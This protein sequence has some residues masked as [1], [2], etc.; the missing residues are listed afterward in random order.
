M[1]YTLAENGQAPKFLGKVSKQG[2]PSNAI[3]ITIACLL[4][5]VFLNYIYPN[6]KLF[7]YI[8]SASILPGMIPWFVLCISQIKFRKKWGSEMGTHPFKSSLFPI[9][10][11]I[12]IIFLCLV[13]VGMW[14][15]D[16]TQVSLIVGAV[17][18]AIITVFYYALGI[19]KKQLP[20]QLDEKL[21]TVDP[22]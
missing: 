18:C 7:V 13:L 6:S 9:S 5:G 19:G 14:F 15:N 8:Y 21:S 16:D 10:N 12:T 2:V 11:Y 20:E 17:F 4:V 3:H 22:E 1:L